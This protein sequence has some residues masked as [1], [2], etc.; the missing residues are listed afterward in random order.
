MASRP[1]SVNSCIKKQSQYLMESSILENLHE[2][3][4]DHSLVFAWTNYTPVAIENKTLYPE[5]NDYS[6]LQFS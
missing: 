1:Y 6:C 5:C 4:E 2:D 3:V